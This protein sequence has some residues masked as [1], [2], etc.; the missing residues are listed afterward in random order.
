MTGS[1]RILWS[2]AVAAL[3]RTA[4]AWA[5]CEARI[6][7]REWIERI[8]QTTAQTMDASAQAGCESSRPLATE[9][10]A[11]SDASVSLTTL[12]VS[13]KARKTFENGRKELGKKE[14][15]HARAV[16]DLERAVALEPGF[17]EAWNLLGETRLALR[18]LEPAS[19]AFE[20]AIAADPR[21]QKQARLSH[22]VTVYNLGRTE[23]AKQAL[24]SILDGGDNRI[25]PR[26][27]F[28]LGELL[29]HERDFRG[30]A[31]LYRDFLKLDSDSRAADRARRELAEWQ[32]KNLIE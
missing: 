32:A 25:A 8:S 20:R 28:L 22:A 5:Q 9:R 27:G 4:C 1:K 29:A 10:P 23:L 11:S 7:P 12:A 31:G 13:G 15:D 18:Q 3:C 16:R 17:A 26:A 19:Q 30:A 21:S 6:S 24:R 2:M 14:P